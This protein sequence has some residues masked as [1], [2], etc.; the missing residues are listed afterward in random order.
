MGGRIWSG[1]NEL[2]SR[3]NEQGCMDYG[4]GVEWNARDIWWRPCV[5]PECFCKPCDTTTRSS[6]CPGR[7]IWLN[8]QCQAGEA[9]T[10]IAS[11]VQHACDCTGTSLVAVLLLSMQLLRRS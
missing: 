3:Q 9:P 6:D 2:H 10:A 8:G 11:R 1:N 4:D 7:C 5:A